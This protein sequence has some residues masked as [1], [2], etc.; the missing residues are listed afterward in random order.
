[1]Q[2]KNGIPKIFLNFNSQ[3]TLSLNTI[4]S[5]GKKIQGLNVA[6]KITY[7]SEMGGGSCLFGLSIYSHI[8]LNEI[9]HFATHFS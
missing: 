4:F 5:Y 6:R 7:N 9:Q 8:S 2:E 1:M 3:Q